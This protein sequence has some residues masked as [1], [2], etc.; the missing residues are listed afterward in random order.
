MIY[1]RQFYKL[2]L[3]MILV[4]QNGAFE[5]PEPKVLNFYLINCQSC[6]CIILKLLS[7]SIVFVFCAAISHTFNNVLTYSFFF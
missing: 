5:N 4:F 1:W 3:L 2:T 6:G 7:F